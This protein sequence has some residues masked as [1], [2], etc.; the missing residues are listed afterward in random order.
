MAKRSLIKAAEELN[1]LFGLSPAID[2]ENTTDEELIKGLTIA[3]KLIR[4]VD[5]EDED[6]TIIPADEFTP[7]LIKTLT[8]LDLYHPP[9]TEPEEDLDDEA[10]DDE[11][12]EEEDEPE[13]ED[14]PNQVDPNEV[15][16]EEAEPTPEADPEYENA[17]EDFDNID[18]DD[19]KVEVVI[20]PKV[21][22]KEKPKKKKTKK[23]LYTKNQAL[24]DTIVKTTEFIEKDELYI[25]VNKTYK[26]KGGTRETLGMM[27][28]FNIY[29]PILV[30]FGIIEV[31][32]SKVRYIQK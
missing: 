11:A 30:L 1:T 10:S 25:N 7:L 19:E 15:S 28:T 24:Y 27:N 23:Y 32:G 2:V 8:K 20:E 3:S 22:V 21:T 16:E 6:G 9:V 14:V 17:D 26:A 13:E 12:A 31:K 29:F 5:E 4:Y 18:D